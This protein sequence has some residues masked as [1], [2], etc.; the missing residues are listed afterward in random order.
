MAAKK[1][2]KKAK[3]VTAKPVIHHKKTRRKN[4][5]IG[6]VWR[7]ELGGVKRIPIGT[8]SIKGQIESAIK[9]LEVVKNRV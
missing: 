5:S 3:T 8:L 9:T 6:C 7:E 2:R 1:R 4:G